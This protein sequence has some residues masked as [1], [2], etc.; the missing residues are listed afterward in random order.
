MVC[1]GAELLLLLSVSFVVA[2]DDRCFLTEGE[3]TA[4]FFVLEDLPVG[5]VLGQLRVAVRI[6]WVWAFNHH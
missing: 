4:S 2:E 1:M 5:S 6:L 3:S